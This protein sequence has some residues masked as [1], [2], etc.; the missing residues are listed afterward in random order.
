MSWMW[1]HTFDVWEGSFPAL[2]A[3]GES[4]LEPRVG[5]VKKL[6]AMKSK[7]SNTF[8]HCNWRNWSYLLMGFRM[9]LIV[10]GQ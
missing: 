10:F 1:K 4:M 8:L 9:R 2:V 5:Y 3:S 7:L 6:R